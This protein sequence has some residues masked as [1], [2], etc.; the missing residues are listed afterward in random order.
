VLNAVYTSSRR[1]SRLARALLGATCW[2]LVWSSIL[3]PVVAQQAEPRNPV[4]VGKL[5]KVV[6][7]DSLVVELQSGPIDVRLYSIDAP[8]YDQPGGAAAA[9]KL[10]E[11]LRGHATLM[12]DVET[13]DKYERVIARVLVTDA[14]GAEILINDEMAKSG[15]AW[16][17]RR[18]MRDPNYCHWEA[19]ARDARIGLWSLEPSQWVYPSDFRRLKRR[20]LEVPE[21][22]SAE[23]AAHCIESIGRR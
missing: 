11:L 8:E 3:P 2:L 17:Y 7:G 13:Q 21:N 10:A 20:E 1:F 19:A 22:F 5:L 12:L 9:A 6:D 14:A 15:H 16:A 18:Y 23:T 4:L